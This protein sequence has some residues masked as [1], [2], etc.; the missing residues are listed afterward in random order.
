MSIFVDHSIKYITFFEA[1]QRRALGMADVPS[2]R[3]NDDFGV[4][5]LFT[6][7]ACRRRGRMAVSSCLTKGRWSHET[8][9]SFSKGSQPFTVNVVPA[10]DG[11][12]TTLVLLAWLRV[13]RRLKPSKR[14]PNSSPPRRLESDKRSG[15]IRQ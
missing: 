14:R 12:K 3:E 11:V 4:F 8:V 1:K 6:D 13:D 15:P 2:C 5:L 9:E 7:D 10:Q